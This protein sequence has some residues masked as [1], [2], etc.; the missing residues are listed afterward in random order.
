MQSVTGSSD[1][2]ELAKQWR[3]RKFTAPALSTFA[4][5]RLCPVT[6]THCILLIRNKQ[7]SSP[8]CKCCTITRSIQRERRFLSQL[9]D[10]SSPKRPGVAGNG[11]Q[12]PSE[13]LFR[14]RCV[15]PPLFLS[16]TWPRDYGARRRP[17]DLLLSNL[18]NPSPPFIPYDES[19]LRTPSSWI[20]LLARLRVGHLTRSFQTHSHPSDFM[21][22]SVY[23][24]S[25]YLA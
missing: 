8:G 11:C 17:S 13:H 23:S 10:V 12:T 25:G 15:N 21:L 14:R 19:S 22:E 18:S 6:R 9:I 4:N 24:Y 1:A 20:P 2:R 16:Y 7:Y 5:W 3:R